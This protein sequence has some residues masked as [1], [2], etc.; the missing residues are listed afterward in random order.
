MPKDKGINDGYYAQFGGVGK[1]NVCKPGDS[2]YEKHYDA[3]K[4]LKKK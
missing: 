2:G 3:I 4:N 1:V